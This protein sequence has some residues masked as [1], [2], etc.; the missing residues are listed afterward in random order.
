MLSSYNGKSFEY[1]DE[2]TFFLA[3]VDAPHLHAAAQEDCSNSQFDEPRCIGREAYAET[4]IASCEEHD[5]N[6]D[7]GMEKWGN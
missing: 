7:A 1:F 2:G 4:P 5:G 3:M 6:N